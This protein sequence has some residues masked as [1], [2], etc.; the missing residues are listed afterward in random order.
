MLPT[1]RAAE[2]HRD[3]III[4]ATCPLLEDKALVGWYREGGCTV[5]APTVAGYKGGAAVAFAS[6]GSWLRHINASDDLAL[7]RRASDIE[8]AK[9][10]GRTGILFHFQGTDPIEDNHDHVDAFAAM[11]VRM[12]Q[13]C[14]NAKN[15]VGDGALERTDSGLSKFG[16]ELV[17]RLNANGVV[18]D[19]AHTG[20]QTTLDAVDR[21]TA[22]VVLSHANARKTY[23]C[24]RNV[25]DDVLR[26]IAGSGGV[27]GTVGFPAFLG[28]DKRP[29]LDRFV[30]DIA[31]KAD[32]VGIDHVGLGIDY[33][34]GQFPVVDD[35]AAMRRYRQR[36]ADTNG[37]SPDE[38]PPP[39]YY[40]P[41][42][43][44]SPRTL[45]KLTERLVGRGFAAEDIKKILGR[46]W[47][48]VFRQVW[49]A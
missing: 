46:N 17:R 22:P 37:W 43:I 8:A 20:R 26:A 45:H 29:A 6:I 19:C 27:I 23:N 1:E 33:F 28:T 48:R 4:D 24:L 34:P 18:V 3:A 15:R 7:I 14:Y 21:S 49:G 47:L 41:A 13:L 38:Y 9:R 25:D 5:V 32:L 40:Y 16:I 31:Y 44:E 36:L 42:G 11:G 10:D 12:I 2:L 30:D 35:D 39:P